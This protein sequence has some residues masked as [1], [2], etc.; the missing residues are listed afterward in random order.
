MKI[1]DL[2]KSIM[3]VFQINLVIPMSVSV[4]SRHGW[5]QSQTFKYSLFEILHIL[6]RFVCPTVLFNRSINVL[7]CQILILRILRQ[8]HQSEGCACRARF[9]AGEKSTGLIQQIVSLEFCSKYSIF[10]V[11]IYHLYLFDSEH[12][13]IIPFR[14][15]S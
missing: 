5:M 3:I 12:S 15:K 1:R 8:F 7:P 2:S 11:N 14:K 6:K 4:N 10:I 13:N 9:K